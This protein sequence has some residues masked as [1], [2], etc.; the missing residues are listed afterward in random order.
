MSAKTRIYEKQTQTVSSSE[1]LRH[2]AGNWLVFQSGRSDE[3]FGCHR[4]RKYLYPLVTD[5]REG[6][7]GLPGRRT[8]HQSHHCGRAIALRFPT[9]RS[10]A[11]REGCWLTSTA[12]AAVNDRFRIVAV[13]LGREPNVARPSRLRV[14]GRLRTAPLRTTRRRPNSQ[15]RTPALRLKSRSRAPAQWKWRKTSPAL[16]GPDLPKN[17]A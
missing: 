11:T 13:A 2:G 7:C 15:A 12:T 14:N 1:V 3:G 8:G 10:R 17:T 16:F 9:A 6:R 4:A 5:R